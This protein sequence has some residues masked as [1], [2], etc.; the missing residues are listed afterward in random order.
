MKLI[1]Y[2][3]RHH[4]RGAYISGVIFINEWIIQLNKFTIIVRWNK[5][6]QLHNL[7]QK[8]IAG[9]FTF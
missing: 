2:I 6:P 7:I 9:T 1:I 4:H 8:Y 3:L 5:W